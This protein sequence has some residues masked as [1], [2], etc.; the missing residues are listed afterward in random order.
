[1]VRFGNWVFVIRC[2][3]LYVGAV[4]P[5]LSQ[6]YL[7]VEVCIDMS[8]ELRRWKSKRMGSRFAEEGGIYVV[9][10]ICGCR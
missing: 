3:S 1:M 10:N 6:G 4:Y 5:R 8:P 7:A 9:F 2:W